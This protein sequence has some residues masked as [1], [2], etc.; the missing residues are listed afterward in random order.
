MF[1]S[2]LWEDEEDDDSTSTTGQGNASGN[3]SQWQLFDGQQWSQ[4]CNDHIIECHYCQPGARGMTIYTNLGCFCV[5]ISPR[6]LLSTWSCG[7][8][9]DLIMTNGLRHFFHQFNRSLHIDFDDMTV[10]GP[11]AGLGVRRQTFLPFNQSQEVG[12]YYKDNTYWCEYGS[13]GS[14]HNTSSVNS[15]DLEQQYN[16]NPRGSFQFKVGSTAYKLDFSAMTQTNLSTLMTRKVRRRPKFNSVVSANSSSMA[17]ASSSL[18]TLSLNPPTAVTWEFIGDEG[19]WMEYQKP[20]SSLDS[21]DIE[22][23]Y[24][25]N[26]QGQLNFT[27]GRYTYTLYFSG[28]YQI[29]N[30]F[31][32]K[33]H[34]R[35]TSGNQHNNS[36]LSQ[37]H[38]QFKD[39][40]GRWKDYVKGSN[41]GRCTVSSQDIEAQ[42]QQNSTGTMSFSTGKFNYQLDFSAMVQTNLSTSTRRPVRRL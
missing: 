42:Y 25:L 8:F 29:S 19:V 12:W 22:K 11:F 10:T 39:M 4:I 15:H 33:R 2:S 3:S 35:R 34:V 37:A 16:S 9:I 7:V 6:Y 36:A 13:Q 26:P 31:G 20:G 18:S 1:S 32:T 28:M 27:A 38:W 24:Q 23:Q 41:R 5:C 40:D 30:T 14:S 17:L 21:M